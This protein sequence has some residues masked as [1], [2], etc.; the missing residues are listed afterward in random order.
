[1][2][3]QSWQG[4]DLPWG[5]L[6]ITSHDHLNM[7]SRKVSWKIWIIKSLISQCLW[8]L[9]LIEWWYTARSSWI[10]S[11]MIQNFVQSD[12]LIDPLAKETVYSE[13]SFI[14]VW[15]FYYV[16]KVFSKENLEIQQ[17]TLCNLKRPRKASMVT[18]NI[19]DYD[20]ASFRKSKR[21]STFLFR[22]FILKAKFL[23]SHF[24]DIF[25]GVLSFT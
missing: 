6:P 15:V 7:W 11:I 24:L 4:G 21:S 14:K 9:N 2:V 12:V 5:V 8:S 3:L 13:K 17:T 25:F 16:K 18:I 20:D 19:V 22:I 1:M 23:K 10:V